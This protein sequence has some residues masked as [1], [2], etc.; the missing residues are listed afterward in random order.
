MTFSKIIVNNSIYGVK[1]S[2]N[3]LKICK[4]IPYPWAWFLGIEGE[5][6][7]TVAVL[8]EITL[9][10]ADGKPVQRTAFRFGQQVS[11][12]SPSFRVLE[13]L[14]GKSSVK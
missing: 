13:E 8:D 2:W 7:G 6:G 11:C 9:L 10:D 3:N 14:R 1:S 4:I 5:A 12:P